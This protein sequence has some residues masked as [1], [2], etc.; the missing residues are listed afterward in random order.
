M[1][2]INL[3]EHQGIYYENNRI[4]LD[5]RIMGSLRSGNNLEKIVSIIKISF[6]HYYN[7]I[8]I[9]PEDK[10]LKN[11]VIKLFKK[12]VEGIQLF[13]NYLDFHNRDTI[14]LENLIDYFTN[15]IDNLEINLVKNCEILK[16]HSAFEKSKLKKNYNFFSFPYIFTRPTSVSNIDLEEINIDYEKDENKDEEDNNDNTEIE[17]DETINLNVEEKEYPFTENDL[18]EDKEDKE[19]KFDFSYIINGLYIGV[20]NIVSSIYNHIFV[21]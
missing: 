15:N 3:I 5:D 17:N 18:K 13:K 7:M 9:N 8:L 16:N 1:V 11:K 10:E 6:L 19:N 20:Y 2:L 14:L 21:Y 12:S 4:Y